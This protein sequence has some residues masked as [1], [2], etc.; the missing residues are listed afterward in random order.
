MLWFSLE[1]YMYIYLSIYIFI[2]ILC[3][4]PC[5]HVMYSLCT[6][7]LLGVTANLTTSTSI[8]QQLH[9]RIVYHLS[10][11]SLFSLVLSKEPPPQPPCHLTVCLF[12]SRLHSQ[13]QCALVKW[14]TPYCINVV[15]NSYHKGTFVSWT[16]SMRWGFAKSRLVACHSRPLPCSGGAES[17]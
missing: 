3:T 12:A 15:V 13:R 2:Y 17:V 5:A 9:H 8:S 4:T 1:V 16:D 7:T 14:P 6:H 11:L 10:G